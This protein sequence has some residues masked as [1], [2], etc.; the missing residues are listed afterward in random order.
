[1]KILQLEAE[2]VKRLKVVSIKP[3]GSL[4]QITGANGEGKSSVLDAIYYALAGTKGIPSEPVRKGAAKAFVRLD[5]GE[6]TVTRRFTSEGSTSLTV[7][8]KGT[9]FSSPQ[10]MLDDLLG[11]LTFDPLEFSRMI[12]R[13]QLNILRTLVKF[14]VDID[15]LERQNKLDFEQRTDVNRNVKQLE[16]QI[17]AIELPETLPD[18][19]DLP[20]VVREMEAASASNV[21]RAQM[22]SD[23]ARRAQNLEQLET[24]IV[25]L[26]ERANTLLAE[27]ERARNE[28]DAVR[29]L[30]LPEPPASIDLSVFQ[31]KIQKA[32]VIAEIHAKA[33]K[34]GE[35][36]RE[37]DAAE[38][39]SFAL[40]QAIG[41]RTMKR[42]DAIANAD[43]P[44]KGLSFD[45]NEV[46]FNKVPFSQASSAEQLRVS[47][48][49]AMVA[50][51][52]LRILRIKDGSLLD[53]KNLALLTKMADK[54]D[55]QIWIERVATDGKVG[56]VMEDGMV[57]AAQPV[58][59]AMDRPDEESRLTGD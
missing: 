29:S 53:S 16:A 25:D 11:K 50:N 2:N 54:Y 3:D 18:K 51:P 24:K 12:P 28:A 14:D 55:Y 35:L 38:D 31:A 32:R 56:I 15:E 57:A 58:V 42:E 5:L 17:G 44:V 20:T 10:K 47:V 30:E 41:D 46:L 36:Q 4:V 34:K 23:I 43:M 40:T 6:F 45:A 19:I 7:E 21:K 48:A 22:E 1:M 8:A 52:K 27:A 9:K 26:R 39:H 13:E 59:A 33:D 49:L 37:R